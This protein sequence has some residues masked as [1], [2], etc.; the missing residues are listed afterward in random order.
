MGGDGSLDFGSTNDALPRF[1]R[2]TSRKSGW[3]GISSNV[4]PDYLNDTLQNTR[5]LFGD[6]AYAEPENTGSN[7]IS[8]FF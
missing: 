6:L 3:R 4:S 2:K 1:S 7:A 5:I 8:A